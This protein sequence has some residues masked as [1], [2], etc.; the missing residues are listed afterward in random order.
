MRLRY[1]LFMIFALTA[2]V[3]QAQGD[4]RDGNWWLEFTSPQ[5]LIY[6]V[7]FLDGTNFAADDFVGRIGLRVMTGDGYPKGCDEKCAAGVVGWAA[8][9]KDDV[10]DKP[11]LRGVLAG[12]LADGLDKIFSDYRNRRILVVN[13]VQVEFESIQGS[14]DSDIEKRL[15]YFRRQ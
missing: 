4:R 13:A 5:K 3:A 12:Q 9:L 14:S 6:I 7:G 2:G 15:E 8:K 1:G 11:S 10:I